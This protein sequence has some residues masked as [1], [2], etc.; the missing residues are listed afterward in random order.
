MYSSDHPICCA[1]D[2][3]FEPS[4]F[5]HGQSNPTYEITT[6]MG[7][8]YVLRKKPPG[9]LLSKSAHRIDREYQVITALEKTN[10]PVPKTYCFCED[11]SIIGTPFYIM[12][13]LDGRI[14]EDPWLPELSPEERHEM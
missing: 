14:F 5:S 4:Q 13:F 8:K 6:S 9:N 2:A 3:N 1:Q 10:V 7:Q 11:S 12:E